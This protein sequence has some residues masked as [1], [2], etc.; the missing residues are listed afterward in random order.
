MCMVSRR[1]HSLLGRIQ[2]YRLE[3]K[4]DGRLEILNKKMIE[5][6]LIFISIY[7]AKTLC[8]YWYFL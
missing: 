3:S 8:F 4:E 1:I 6:I 2:N 7:F 5:I